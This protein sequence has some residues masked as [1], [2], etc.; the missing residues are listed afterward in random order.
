M[1]SPWKVGATHTRRRPMPPRWQ[2][3]QGFVS[4]R[5]CPEPGSAASRIEAIAD[6]R[7]TGTI[8]VVPPYP[9]S[10]VPD[11]VPTV[12]QDGPAR[13]R[14]GKGVGSRYPVRPTATTGRGA[15]TG[16]IVPSGPTTASQRKGAQSLVTRRPRLAEHRRRSVEPGRPARSRCGPRLLDA[17]LRQL[18]APVSYTH[19][20]AHET[21]S[22][23]VCR[24]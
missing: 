3:R 20:R 23:L 19:L 21:D 4:R 16:T 8:L 14:R 17:L 11:P 10:R 6:C 7:E 22:Y 12:E 9:A 18:S 5:A 2:F 24:L 13:M 15:D 1:V